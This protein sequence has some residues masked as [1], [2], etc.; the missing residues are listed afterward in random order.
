MR[1]P[2]SGGLRPGCWVLVTGPWVPGP[3]GLGLWDSEVQGFLSK[4]LGFIFCVMGL[5]ALVVALRIKRPTD[6]EQGSS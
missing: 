6:N 1:I 5:K 2:G 3:G 4:I